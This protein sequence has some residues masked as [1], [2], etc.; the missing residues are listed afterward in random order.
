MRVHLMCDHKWRDLPNLTAIKLFLE[1]LGHTVTVMSVKDTMAMLPLIRPDCI[2]FNWFLGTAY[3]E[4]AKKLR[5]AGI[6]IV[7]LPTEGSPRPELMGL[8]QGEFSDYSLVD[9]FLSWSEPVTSEIRRRGD[10]N[11]DRVVT[12][13]CTRFDFYR[14]PL[15]RVIQGRNAFCRKH[16]ID[17]G[18]PIVT[19]ATQYGYAY[20]HNGPRKGI[21]QFLHEM[22]DFGVK[23]CYDR[24]GY[25]FRDL[26][27]RHHHGRAIVGDAFFKLAAAMPE[28]AFVIKP[29]PIEDLSFYRARIEEL[30]TD[31][32]RFCFGE[33]I[34]DVLGATDVLLHRQCTTAVEAW[35][36]NLPTIETGMDVHEHFQWPEREAG[37]DVAGDADELIALVSEYL[38]GRTVDAERTAYRQDYVDQWF[39]NPDGNGCQAAARRIHELLV[40]RGPRRRYFHAM[41]R[42]SPGLPTVARA[43]LR[44]AL[45]LPASASVKQVLQLNGAG[46]GKA[47]PG[48]EDKLISRRDLSNYQD[49]LR[50]LVDIQGA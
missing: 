27:D 2:V 36:S 9:L 30:P 6:A 16:D 15:K 38:R 49:N 22:E 13:G 20:L 39:G 29:H 14:K 31:N 28:V 50:P 48:A 23:A 5:N 7:V 47:K 46:D 43:S 45:G 42:L 18:R 33:Y 32:I 3:H 37:S 25:D 4:F 44:Y 26:P 41:S 1:R 21:E 40:S 34:W 19:W 12:T 11:A 35:M 24:I 10:M 17:S 8:I